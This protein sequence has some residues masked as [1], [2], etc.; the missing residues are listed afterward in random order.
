MSWWVYLAQCGDRSL[1]TGVTTDPVRRM[2]Q[3]NAGHGSRYVRS[4]KRARLL[5]LEPCASRAAALRREAE[6]KGWRRQKKLALV[7]A[8]R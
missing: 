3:H 2:A 6:V 5:Y 7:H 1:Y 4:R 8:S